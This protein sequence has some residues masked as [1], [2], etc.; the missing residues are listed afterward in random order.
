MDDADGRRRGFSGL[1]AHRPARRGG[2]P[3]VKKRRIKKQRG[4]ILF[5][6]RVTLWVTQDE[7]RR[8]A[9]QRGIEQES[10]L[11]FGLV[12]R[13]NAHPAFFQPAARWLRQKRIGQMIAWKLALDQTTHE[14]HW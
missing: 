7:R 11:A 12:R 8:R 9:A 3:R 13:A 1:H 6:A 4:Q 10:L 2:L 14:H 5:A